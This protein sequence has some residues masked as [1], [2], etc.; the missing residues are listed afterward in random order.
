MIKDIWAGFVFVHLAVEGVAVASGAGDGDVGGVD[1]GG[2]LEAEH[3]A[4]RGEGGVEAGHSG[5]DGGGENLG[6]V[7]S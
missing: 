3:T 4:H 5:K 2:G 6:L 1:A 7:N